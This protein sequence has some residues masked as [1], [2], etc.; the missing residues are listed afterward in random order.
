MSQVTTKR[1]NIL[2]VDDTPENLAILTSMLSRQGYLVR[3]AISGE[4]A[5]KAVR[6]NPPDVILLDIMMPHMSGYEVCEQLKADEQT[7]D[8]PVIFI[9]ALHKVFDKVKAFSLGGVDYITKPFQLEEVLAR[10]ET[11][12]TL[13]SLHRELQE[14]NTQLEHEIAERIRAETALKESLAQIERAKQEW[15]TTADSLSYVVCL[16]DRH[17]HVIRVNRTAEHWK[18]GQVE[19]MKGRGMHELFHPGCTDPSCYLSTFLAHAWE[20]VAQGISIG[21]EEHDAILQRYVNVQIRPLSA[22][23]EQDEEHPTSF[24]VGV[25]SD[26]TQRKQA[27]HSLRQHN[28]ALDILNRMSDQFQ[29][30]HA[31]YDTYDVIA[32]ACQ[33]LFPLDSGAL[34]IM[35]TSSGL[36]HTATSWGDAVPDTAAFS[37]EECWSC[38]RNA[39]YVVENPETQTI[40]AHAKPSPPYGYLCSPI[41]TPEQMLGILHLRFGKCE[42]AFSEEECK[43]RIEIRHTVVTR[44]TKH[45]ALALVNLRLRE[46]LRLEAIRDPLTGLYNRRYMEESLLRETER[47]R[48][49]VT[50]IG[51]LMFDIDHFK[52]LNDTYGHETG[53]LVLQKLGELF[54]KYTRS[55]DVACRYGGE[56]FLLIM[57]ETS[58]SIVK[59]RAEELR[60]LVKNQ[61]RIPYQGTMLTITISVGVAEFPRHGLYIK[62]VVSAADAALYQAKANGRD[63][64]A[65]AAM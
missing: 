29:A 43:R 12:L 47:A 20:E 18:L 39:T 51:I 57:P 16:L 62:D 26:I 33:E 17:G 38:T 37:S 32:S 2:V 41:R 10:V 27:E 31:E 7:R 56:E 58:L 55:E 28:Y 1:G 25:V 65:I 63:Q 9:S 64:I 49:R 4:V 61:L 36:F 60:L 46:T 3:P 13:R 5:L 22:R 50:P 14:N 8:I 59:Q 40:C 53:D 23:L 44:V 52:R 45:Y 34:Y 11:H 15:E 6:K 54:L 48:R 30:C 35:T 24:A 21:C 42:P 19:A